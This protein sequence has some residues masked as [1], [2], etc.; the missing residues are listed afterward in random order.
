[1]KTS[2]HQYLLH[3]GEV[4]STTERLLMPGQTGFMNGWGVFTTIRVREGVLFEW[5][6]HFARMRRDADVMRVPF[7][8]DPAELR[9]GLLRL[10]EA[11]RAYEAT[12][13]VAV[14]RNRGG[15]FEAPGQTR[16][17]DTVAFT[18]D[19]AD[20]GGGVRMF[21]VPHGRYAASH[22]AG[23]KVT[24]WAQNL[25][26][27]EEAHQRGFDEVL[28][29]NER[30]EL[31]ECTSANIFLAFGDE[32]FTPPL[33]SGCLPGITRDILVHLESADRAAPKVRERTLFPADLEQASEVFITSTTR[34]LLQ[35]V[36]VE[37][38][39]I[40]QGHK[41]QAALSQVFEEYQ[42]AYVERAKQAEVGA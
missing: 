33:S 26:W 22:F 25:A 23:T 10:I 20:W 7:Y 38:L 29:L 30:G 39:R 8:S 18:A 12:L 17:F 28:L 4:R 27:Y 36:A 16:D 35:V 9:A 15:L 11:N 14:M 31:S 41:M 40:A 21:L 2:M 3:N 19:L 34:D 32:V 6:R 13:R 24:S 37:G 42:K 5:D 1:M